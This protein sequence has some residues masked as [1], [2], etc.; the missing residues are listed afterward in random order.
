MPLVSP[1]LSRLNWYN[2][3]LAYLSTTALFLTM[4]LASIDCLVNP[5]RL[6]FLGA[7]L[8]NTYV[9]N[10]LIRVFI[11]IL[12]VIFNFANAFNVSIIAVCGLGYEF[13]LTFVLT[14]EFSMNNRAR[15]RASQSFRDPKTLRLYYRSFQILNE[16]ALVIF[17]P[18]VLWL[19]VALTLIPIFGNC[20]LLFYWNDLRA[21]SRLAIFM[22]IGFI[23]PFW[24]LVLELGKYLYTK[25]NQVLFSWKGH[26]WGIIKESRIMKRF[27]T[28][29]RLVLIRC[30]NELV[31][32][33]ITPFN[34]LKG[35]L[36]GTFRVL[37]V[38]NK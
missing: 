29:C 6:I 13:Y 19:H 32:S 33:R 37:L 21:L 26:N 28:S 23:L 1:E 8:P 4:T 34:Y 5:S 31:L 18:A 11:S 22:G 2:D 15:Y 38:L 36:W 14:K 12:H 30:G 20:A 3:A 17:G 9:Q 27:R 25:G 10:M 24:T 7:L 16:N 35:V